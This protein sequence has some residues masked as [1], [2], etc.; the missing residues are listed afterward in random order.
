VTTFIRSRD[1]A[2]SP[3][4]T[5]VSTLVATVALGAWLCGNAYEEIV[6]VPNFA[7][8][9]VQATMAAFRAFFQASN[10]VLYYVPIGPAV[11]VTSILNLLVSWRDPGP[12]AT[13]AGAAGCVLLA[14]LLTA[15]IVVHVNLRLFFGP[16]M[17][18]LVEARSLARQWLVLNAIRMLV[19]GV[20]VFL[21]RRLARRAGAP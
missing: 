21:V 11:V 9:D 14:F 18:D 6:I 3:R 16:V 4:L 17:D 19:V 7:G 1:T 20:A 2:P 15:W 12:R 5:A 13:A 10:P 8:G